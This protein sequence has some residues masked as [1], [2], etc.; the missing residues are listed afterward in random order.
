MQMDMHFF[1]VYS[2]ARA[3]GLNPSTANTI[4]HASQFVDDAVDDNHV[5]FG[6]K[7]A[8]VPTMTS[9]KPL[10]YQNAIPGDQWK[11]WVP[12]HFLPGDAPNASSFIERM[13]CRADSEPANRMLEDALKEEKEPYWPHLIGIAAHVYM[14]TFSHFGFVGFSSAW[15]KVRADSIDLTRNSPGILGYIKE[16]YEE[17]LTRAGGIFAEAIPVGHG[18]VATF[19]DRPY[20]KWQFDYES[21]HDA[22]EEYTTRNNAEVFLNGC[23]NLYEFFQKFGEAC[24]PAQDPAGPKAWNQMTDTVLELLSTAEP[25][26]E[27]ILAWKRKMTAGTLFNPVSQDANIKYSPDNWQPQ[28][29]KN[30]RDVD[31]QMTGTDACK[32]I[33]AAWRHRTYVLHELLPDIGLVS[34]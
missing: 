34:F 1:G 22:P 31:Q 24:P 33:R 9:H 10:D 2:L 12:F 15:N 21:H 25:C 27:R 16:K 11:V 20:L 32:F 19:P 28:T 6:R 3:A 30:T 5:V 18:A 8:I 23:Q 7:Q 4:A 26:D 14:D 13:V 29:L 17:F